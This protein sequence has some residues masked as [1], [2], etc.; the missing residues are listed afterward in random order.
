MTEPEAPG[1]FLVSLGTSTFDPREE[2]GRRRTRLA[3]APQRGRGAPDP[4][5]TRIV[6]V[7]RSLMASDMARLHAEHGLALTAYVPNLAYVERIDGTTVRRLR[8]DHL[9]RAVTHYLPEYKLA[10]GLEQ[11]AR[12]PDGPFELTAVL[13][14]GADTDV[15]ATLLD[16]I[17]ARDVVVSDPRAIGGLPRARFVLDALQP[18]LRRIT[19]LDDVRFVSAAARIV[20]DDVPASSVIQ[21]GREGGHQ[22]WDRGLTGEG[23]IIGILDESPVDIN[24]EF[25]RGAMPKEAGPAHRKVVQIRQLVGEPLTRHSTI[26]AGCAVGDHRTQPGSHSNR[27]MAWAA[28]MTSSTF[29]MLDASSLITELNAAKEAGAFIHSNSWHRDFGDPAPYT[30]IDVDAD[31]FVYTYEDHLVLGS[32][33]NRTE[34]QGPPGTSKNTVCVS[35]ATDGDEPAILRDGR[36]GP[37]LDGRRKPD[38]VAVGTNVT[39][40]LF[41]TADGTHTSTSTSRATAHAAGAAALIRQY[42]TD[43]WYPTGEKIAGN[44]VQPTGSLLKAALVASTVDMTGIAGFP[45]DAEGWGII[46]LQNLLFF[47]GSRRRFVPFD[48]RHAQGPTRG[49]T[50]T[51]HVTIDDSEELRVV[52]VWADPP[53]TV[54]QPPVRPQVNDLDLIVTAPSGATFRGNQFL[55]GVSDPDHLNLTDS[56]NNV[57]VVRVRTPEAGRWTVAV[58]AF[59]IESLDNGGR[60]GYAVV[61]C[62]A[63]K[64][65]CFVASIVYRDPDHIDVCALRDWRDRNLARRTGAGLAMR[66][67]V[68]AY[69]V[70]GPVAAAVV[71]RF[72][73]VRGPLR[74]Q[75]LH[76]LARR[77]DPYRAAR[78]ESGQEV[79]RWR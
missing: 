40:A 23:Q 79:P 74:T 73:V 52:L 45:N 15:V 44:A 51:H 70:L 38:V 12:R 46:R 11:Q 29:G 33:G 35:A 54:G 60:Q 37:T 20:S 1:E 47:R 18:A 56:L 76:R 59:A 2:Q 67:L 10:P 58:H 68:R 49:E 14:D 64:S 9:V 53:G 34:Q 55:D 63:L 30:D 72:P 32:S 50:R 78:H 16:D 27:G 61:V 13:F 22:I 41:G 21:S 57:E 77:V 24:H 28:R 6:Q 26:V 8:A 65:N 75:V 43:G 5:Q 7:K 4:A 39:S 31:M 42:F 48:V 71:E 36:S 3:P 19:D 25:F 62:A 69:A 17:G 66:A